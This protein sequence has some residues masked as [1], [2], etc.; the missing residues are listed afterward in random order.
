MRGRRL[1]SPGSKHSI[2]RQARR[3][4]KTHA[5]NY[6]S[7]ASIDSSVL[8]LFQ[9]SHLRSFATT[10]ATPHNLSHS[11]R[12][13]RR[14]IR[15]GEL[16]HPVRNAPSGAQYYYWRGRSR[17]GRAIDEAPRT[18]ARR[19][20]RTEEPS[21]DRRSP[22]PPSSHSLRW[23]IG[24]SVPGNATSSRVRNGDDDYGG[25]DVDDRSGGEE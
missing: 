14:D 13:I 25:Q 17:C 3:S 19:S 2:C 15:S 7:N 20:R 24:A 16:Q 22:P 10:A 18:N 4:L 11:H 12:V 5:I 6:H 1:R 9:Q 8:R 23:F 21:P